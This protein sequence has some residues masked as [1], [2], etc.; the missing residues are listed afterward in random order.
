VQSTPQLNASGTATAAA[1][2]AI[3]SIKSSY[4]Q[5]VSLVHVVD[6]GKL[7]EPLW[8]ALIATAAKIDS[9]YD[10]A[11]ALSSIAAAMPLDDTTKAAYRK[12]ADAIGSEYDRSRAHDALYDRGA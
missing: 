5:R 8:L 2:R 3:G 1:I 6:Q 12:A 11:E 7:D 10:R 9:D 4:D